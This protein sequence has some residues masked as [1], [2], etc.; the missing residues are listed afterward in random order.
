MV[1]KA[2]GEKK[3]NVIKAVREVTSLGLKEAK[4]L[5]EAAPATVKEGGLE[6]RGRVDQEEVRRGRGDGRDQVSVEG[7]ATTFTSN[8]TTV[9]SARTIRRR[10]GCRP[11]HKPGASGCS[12]L[13]FTRPGDPP[14]GER[15]T[16]H[17]AL[18]LPEPPLSGIR[19]K[20][21]TPPTAVTLVAA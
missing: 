15:G 1:L 20:I 13:L 10:N 11:G 5:V 6:G 19:V 9:S 7:E 18:L 12:G 8:W 17:G 2:A 4:D 21:R 14:R 3:I 16:G